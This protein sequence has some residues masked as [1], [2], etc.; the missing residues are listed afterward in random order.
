M[1][2]VE[3][4]SKV[5]LKSKILK[6][7]KTP[8]KAP[9]SKKLDFGDKEFTFLYTAH[10]VAQKIE[11]EEIFKKGDA[12]RILGYKS[13]DNSYLSLGILRI[14]IENN[15]IFTA[16]L[17]FPVLFFCFDFSREAVFYFYIH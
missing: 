13:E 9:F 10:A 16:K 8:F 17:S 15:S 11:G 14:K 12:E 7:V 4:R 6:E 1:N 3:F 2:V 5:S